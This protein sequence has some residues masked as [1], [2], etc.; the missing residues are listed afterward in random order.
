MRVCSTGM[1]CGHCEDL[2]F[3]NLQSGIEGRQPV[4][5]GAV[6]EQEGRWLLRQE[7]GKRNESAQSHVRVQ[8]GH[9][10]LPSL[11]HPVLC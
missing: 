11:F 1:V 5:L 6:E 9:L 2:G 7:E 4:F 8:Q 10:L 3:A